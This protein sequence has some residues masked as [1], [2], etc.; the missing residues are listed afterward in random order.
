M[1]RHHL[2]MCHPDHRQAIPNVA[3][4]VRYAAKWQPAGT[5]R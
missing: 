5:D 1:A 3:P 2:F 4:A